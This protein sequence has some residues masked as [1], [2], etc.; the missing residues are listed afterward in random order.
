MHIEPRTSVWHHV[1]SALL[2]DRRSSE[3]SAV[4]AAGVA[5]R[6]DAQA[7]SSHVLV[8]VVERL[9]DSTIAVLWQDATR[10]CYLDQVWINCRARAKG[11]CALTGTLIHRG[12]NVYKPRSRGVLP[13]NAEAMIVAS[14]ITAV[15]KGDLGARPRQ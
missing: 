14:A 9:T 11:Y 5:P 12:D 2:A 8:E 7:P 15:R 10:C 3:R 1:V 6:I 4:H 13:A